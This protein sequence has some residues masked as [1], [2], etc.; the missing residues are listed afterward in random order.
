[1][2]NPRIDAQVCATSTQVTGCNCTTGCFQQRCECYASGAPCDPKTCSC[3]SCKNPVAGF[4][5]AVRSRAGIQSIGAKEVDLVLRAGPGGLGKPLQYDK[6][7]VQLRAGVS[8]RAII[9]QICLI[10][11]A[12]AQ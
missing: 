12:S 4:I 5:Q 10:Y 7:Q 8:A 2:S 1:M 6:L 9:A 3:V 11:V